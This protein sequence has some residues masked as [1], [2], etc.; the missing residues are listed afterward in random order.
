MAERVVL[1]TGA[2]DG[3]GK[4]VA[5]RFAAEGARVLLHGRDAAKGA[6]VLAELTA[7]SGNDRLELYRADFASLEEVRWMADEIASRHHRLDVL[8]NNAGIGAAHGATLARSGPVE[9]AGAPEPHAPEPLAKSRDGYELRL[10]VNHLAA[11][12]LTRSL[13]PLLAASEAPRVV[14]VS[15]IGQS[16]ID[17]DDVM[18][19]QGQDEMHAYR[20]SKFAQVMFAFE[21]AER[22]RGVGLTAVAVHPASFMATKMVLEAGIAPK[23]T[24]EEG[25]AAIWRA[26]TAPELAGGSELFFNGV[27]AARARDE[28]AYDRQARTRFWDL[29]ADLTGL[30]R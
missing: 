29:S 2:T 24:P 7:A 25:A 13:E 16:P 14:Q 26:A 11:Y 21:L 28:Q 30:P 10:A 20:Q 27:E 6:A 18:L 17:F 23:S 4:L 9:R 15:S 3:V 12:L 22:W 1:V 5:A 19:T 8:I